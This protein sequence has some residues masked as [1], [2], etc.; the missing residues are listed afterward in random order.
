MSIL[1]TNHHKIFT[2][3]AR[4]NKSQDETENEEFQNDGDYDDYEDD[5]EDDDDSDGPMPEMRSSDLHL[6]DNPGNTVYLPCETVNSGNHV[7]IF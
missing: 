1:N 5:T 3:H 2:V 6:R 4:P 7:F